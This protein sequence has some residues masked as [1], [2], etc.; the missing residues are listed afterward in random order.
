[1]PAERRFG[2]DHEHYDWSPRTLNGDEMDE[3]QIYVRVQSPGRPVVV[4]V[5]H[6]ESTRAG[7]HGNWGDP[8]HPLF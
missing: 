8:P 5:V 3:S 4:L 7:V 1:M 6:P 2:M